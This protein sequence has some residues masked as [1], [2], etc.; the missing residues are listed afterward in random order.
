LDKS[1]PFETI[2]RSNGIE[3]STW[4]IALEAASPN[5]NEAEQKKSVNEDDFPCLK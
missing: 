4:T 5:A 1:I 3:Y 2:V